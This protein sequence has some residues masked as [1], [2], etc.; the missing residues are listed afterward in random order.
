V[1]AQQL[2]LQIAGTRAALGSGADADDFG[3]TDRDLDL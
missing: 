2:P 3:A 1:I